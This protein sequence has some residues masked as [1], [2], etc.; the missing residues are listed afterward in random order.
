MPQNAQHGFSLCGALCFD[1]AFKMAG[2]VSEDPSRRAALLEELVGRYREGLHTAPLHKKI[3]RRRALYGNSKPLP[4]RT[5]IAPQWPCH[6]SGA[7]VPG[8]LYGLG[9]GQYFRSRA[10]NGG[11]V[12]EIVRDF[13]GNLAGT[14]HDAS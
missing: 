5:T 3:L 13:N 11:P 10:L 9:T 4:A 14:R 7:L 12:G 1:V 8:F 2:L 6:C